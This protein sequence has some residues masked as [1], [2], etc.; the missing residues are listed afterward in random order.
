MPRIW[1]LC[2]NRFNEYVHGYLLKDGPSEELAEAIRNIM[3]GKREFASELIFGSIGKENPLS[4]REREILLLIEEG[5]SIKDIATTLYLSSGTIRNYISEAIGKLGA[6][7]R[8]E[9]I[10]EARRNGWL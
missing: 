7:N 4:K 6:K 1:G 8:I 9:T 3:R 2:F 10:A 5:K